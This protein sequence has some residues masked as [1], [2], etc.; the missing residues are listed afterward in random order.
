METRKRVEIDLTVLEDYFEQPFLGQNQTDR[1]SF[2]RCVGLC[3]R[4]DPLL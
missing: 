1:I 3:E 4:N 2:K